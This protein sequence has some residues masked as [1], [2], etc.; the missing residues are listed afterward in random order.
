[1]LCITDAY[2]VLTVKQAQIV[3]KYVEH[4]CLL[5][6]FCHHLLPIGTISKQ[7]HISAH[8]IL[9]VAHLENFLYPPLLRIQAFEASGQSCLNRKISQLPTLLFAN[10]FD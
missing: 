4:C 3:S 9:F 5:D 2:G 8:T 10:P 1:M 6:C 7:A